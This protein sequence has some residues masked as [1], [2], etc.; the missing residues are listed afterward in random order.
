MSTAVHLVIPV[1]APVWPALE[2]IAH[3]RSQP[4]ALGRVCLYHTDDARSSR[5]FARRLERFTAEAYPDLQVQRREGG[6]EP[7]HLRRQL[8]TWQ[9]DTADEPWVIDLTIA[10]RRMAW[11]V[12]SWLERPNCRVVERDP[13]RGWI[14]LRRGPEGDVESGPLA[15]FRRDNTEELSIAALVR[16]LWIESTDNPALP[17]VSQP[18][19]TLPMVPLTEA[20]LAARW[21]WTEA[22]RA[23]GVEAP[24]TN[25][26]EER[27][28]ARYLAGFVA[29]LG[30]RN[31]VLN[32]AGTG[33]GE[34]W[35][36]TGGRLVVIEPV[37]ESTAGP[38]PSTNS[39]LLDRLDRAGRIRAG[40]P[41][42]PVE[43]H[44]VC[45]AHRASAEDRAL[46]RALGLG[47]I[48]LEECHTLPSRLAA[49]FA[50]PLGD[51][52]IEVERQLRAHLSRTGRTRVFID[53]PAVLQSRPSA[54]ADPLW[55][56]ADAWL[57]QVMR[58]RGQNWLL[59]THR[60]RA[61][62]CAPVD[63]RPAAAQEWR[64]LVIHT[65]GLDEREVTVLPITKGGPVIVEFPESPGPN[66]RVAAWLK[67]FQNRRVSF[68][69]AQARFAVQARV[70][71]EAANAAANSGNSPSTGSSRT[72]PPSNMAA[73]RL[74]ATPASPASASR[75]GASRTPSQPPRPRS[76]PAPKPVKD[77]LADLDRA[78]DDALGG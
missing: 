41:G 31:V 48:D 62:L 21:Q 4:G 19:P 54:D 39:P 6:A 70:E 23:A 9:T 59:S 77:P 68:T 67:P 29:Q 17:F 44:L 32:T 40:F 46:A 36:N 27:L 34:I 45:P 25:P 50:L 61:F 16:A 11:S 43:W 13:A 24:D 38:E 1:G 35:I 65:S 49:L 12:E 63:G 64:L 8:E 5:D 14:E 26:T 47:L 74:P 2:S 3:W 76:N 56:Q 7:R 22:F 52:G 20:A 71:A 75:P 37:L 58:E 53:E 55:A 60:G 10:P 18:A 69:E 78:L 15:E 72:P 66:R 73:G 42:A 51:V 28:F 57:E 30:L 33:P